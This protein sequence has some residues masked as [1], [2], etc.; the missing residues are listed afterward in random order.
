MI[1]VVHI[2]ENPI[3]G[4]PIAL[5][6]AL[7]EYGNGRIQSRHIASS[8]RNE[9]RVF[10]SD[11]LI[12]EGNRDVITR[13]IKDAD[14]I[15][16]H[17]FYHQQELFR[18]FPELWPITQRKKR[19]WQV[20]SQRETSWVDLETPYADKTMKRLVI[21]QYHPRQWTECEVVP[22]IVPIFDDAYLP[23]SIYNTPPR[24]VYTPSRIGLKGWDNKGY[25]ETA[26]VLQQLV[27]ERLAT[28]NIVYNKTHAECM[29]TRQVADIAIDEIVTGSYHLCSLEALSQ[30][31]ATIAG[32]D[33]IQ[34]KTLLDFTGASSLPWVVA[35]PDTLLEVIKNLIKDSG[36]L[37]EVRKQGRK[38]ME[39]YWHPKTHVER[40][41]GIYEKL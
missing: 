1:K 40:F 12:H 38:W 39:Q 6:N 4:A 31:L 37:Q 29:E 41:L 19:V 18:K 8:D 17:N 22:N 3:A 33:K 24:I 30:G 15:H 27:K 35:K 21:A 36:K 2:T 7:S 10:K 9:N 25:Y 20:H 34:E 28:A 23:K 14:I 26:P 11:V 32:L 13:L 5:S 16:F